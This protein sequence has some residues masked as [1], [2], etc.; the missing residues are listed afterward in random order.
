M[1]APECYTRAKVN[2]NDGLGGRRRRAFLPSEAEFTPEYLE[3]DDRRNLFCATGRQPAWRLN[4]AFLAKKSRMID[5]HYRQP[6]PL[7][8]VAFRP[9]R[10]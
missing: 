8:L 1:L 3:G 6:A 2:D 7:E 4:A 9:R 10:A 5:A